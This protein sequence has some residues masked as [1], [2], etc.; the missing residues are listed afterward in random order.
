MVS[1][2]SLSSETKLCRISRG[3]HSALFSFLTPSRWLAALAA[4]RVSSL[5]CGPRR[6]LTGE[7]KCSQISRVVARNGRRVCPLGC[8]KGRAPPATAVSNWTGT[9]S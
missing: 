2:L 3:V 6:L 7:R 4:P 5:R 1:P 9:N 8:P